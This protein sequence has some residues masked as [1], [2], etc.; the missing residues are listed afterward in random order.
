MNGRGQAD[1]RAGQ[2]GPS[3]RGHA[4]QSRVRS[5]RRVVPSMGHR[6]DAGSIQRPM[7]R[8]ARRGDE[9]RVAQAADLHESQRSGRLAGGSVLSG[10]AGGYAG[11]QR[12]FGVALGAPADSYARVGRWA[13][14]A[15]EHHRTGGLIG[16]P[17]LKDWVSTRR[18]ARRHRLCCAGFPRTKAPWWSECLRGR[19]MR[20]SA[21]WN[22]VRKQP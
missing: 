1:R 22:T 21:G 15:C 18:R 7:W 4:T 8:G 10:R 14:G 20:W 5:G 6:H 2:F 12:R 17:P 9:S 19:P 13:Q 16:V 3:I 11:D